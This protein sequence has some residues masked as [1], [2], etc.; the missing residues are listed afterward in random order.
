MIEN[1]VKVNVED[2]VKVGETVYNHLTSCLASIITVFDQLLEANAVFIPANS[3][4]SV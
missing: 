4:L 2:N 1:N 3:S